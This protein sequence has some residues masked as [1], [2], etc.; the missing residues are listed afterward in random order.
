M[1]AEADARAVL[2]VVEPHNVLEPAQ[3]GPRVLLGLARLASGDTAAAL[4][5][6]E[7][8]AA[9]S[10]APSMLL[11]RR[12][13]IAAYGSALQVAGRLD[14]AVAV[15]RSALDAPGEDVRSSCVARITLARALSAAG[16]RDEARAVAAEAVSLAYA[17]EQVSERAAA[18]ELLATLGTEEI[19]T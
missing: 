8:V 16:K 1:S 7:P 11:P 13:A 15:G 12:L 2:D 3:V 6:L 5:H 17:S 9:A 18:D 14:D 4:R 10:P 19:T